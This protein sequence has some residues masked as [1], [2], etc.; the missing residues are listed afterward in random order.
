LREETVRVLVINR[1]GDADCVSKTC[2][3]GDSQ[4]AVRDED[5]D[6]GAGVAANENGDV[7]GRSTEV[8]TLNNQRSTRRADLKTK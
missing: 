8:E 4:L 2:P 3:Y 1:H 7:V 6:V 5:G